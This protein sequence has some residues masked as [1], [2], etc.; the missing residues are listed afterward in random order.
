MACPQYKLGGGEIWP[1]YG[2]LNSNTILQ[3]DLFC[4]K[5]SEVPYVQVIFALREN[6]EL[7]RTCWVDSA[8]LA[9]LNLLTK[10]PPPLLVIL[11]LSRQ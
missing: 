6:P 2:S 10:P 1:E 5:W 4:R 9:M 8:D 7:Y 11:S 3:R